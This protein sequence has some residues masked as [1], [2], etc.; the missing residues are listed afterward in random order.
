[1]LADKVMVY[2]TNKLFE[3]E[4]LKNY[5]SDNGVISF[6]IDKRDSS[7]LFGEIEIYVNRDE[8]IKAKLLIEKF[9]H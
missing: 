3:A 2:T 7:Y 5:L 1:M 6:S 9:E 8:V 4:L